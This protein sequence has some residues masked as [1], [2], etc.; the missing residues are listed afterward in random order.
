MKF[1]IRISIEELCDFDIATINISEDDRQNA[2]DAFKCEME[3][4]GL[5]LAF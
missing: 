3:Y 1:T 4:N 2:E 5:D